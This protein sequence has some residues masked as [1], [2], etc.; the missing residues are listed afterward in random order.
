MPDRSFHVVVVGGGLAGAA[1]AYGMRDL[2]SRLA[3]LDEGDVAFRAARGN[4][5]LIWVQ[6]K[7]LG[8]PD[9]AAWTRR[10]AGL[11]PEFAAALQEETGLDVRY[12]RPG[13][14]SVALSER[15]LAALSEQL[16]RLHNQRGAP[17]FEYEVID[18]RRLAAMLPAI[19]PEV[20]GAAYSPHDGHVNSLRLFRA[21]HEATA[22][23]GVARRPL[24][25]VGRIAPLPGGGFRLETERGE[26]RA[27]K[28]VI[29]AGHG[30]AGLA[31][32]VGLNA[33]VRPQR[34]QILVTE[35]VAPFL[36]HP[37]TT[38]RQTDEGGVMIGDSLEEV[39]FDDRVAAGVLGAMADR[40][41]RTFPFLSR[42]HVLRSWAALRVMSPD[43][44]PIYEQSASAPGAF[45]VTCHSGVTLAAAHAFVLPPLIAA[46]AL[47]A[48][49]APFAS[50]RFGVSKAA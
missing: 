44:F 28:V 8:M 46:G 25:R 27:A 4:F 23:H 43:G 3:V 33:P 21:L 30:N 17:G 47:S 18:R 20:A 26:V 5:G 29:A 2:G 42:V 6:G 45:L 41:V 36:R 11:W 34:G 32:M 15:E 1:I 40:A 48:D 9:Y 22:R 7:G 13:G 37:I 14:L 39:G 12:E 19:G 49:L 35:K 10:S 16:R 24:H 50:R 38:L 31:A